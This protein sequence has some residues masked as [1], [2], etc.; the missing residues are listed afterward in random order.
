MTA[1][2]VFEFPLGWLFGLPL[3]AALAYAVWR[4]HQRGLSGSKIITLG[5]LRATALLL[6]IFLAACP[7]WLAGNRRHRPPARSHC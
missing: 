2:I 4:Q 3:T 7:V 6:L 5:A 1:T